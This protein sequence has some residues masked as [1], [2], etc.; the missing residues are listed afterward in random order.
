MSSMNRLRLSDVRTMQLIFSDQETVLHFF[1]CVT[2]F[3]ISK[4]ITVV[5]NS[6]ALPEVVSRCGV[7]VPNGDPA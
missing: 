2:H 5:S 3:S 6:G 1:T 7:V 4:C